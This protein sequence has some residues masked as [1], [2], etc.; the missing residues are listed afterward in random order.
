MTQGQQKACC[1]VLT[2][3][4]YCSKAG[5]LSWTW[6]RTLEVGSL[7]QWGWRERRK[8]EG[9]ERAEERGRMDVDV[10]SGAPSAHNVGA[11]QHLHNNSNNNKHEWWGIP[12]RLCISS[13]HRQG[14]KKMQGEYGCQS[15][16]FSAASSL[17]TSDRTAPQFS[18][19][20]LPR[21]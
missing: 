10:P 12:E 6:V 11:Y 8:L 17:G 5:Q 14:K 16:F 21:P 20:A 4:L 1:F 2:I 7:V 18:S 13:I 19:P 15:I 9:R 3:Q